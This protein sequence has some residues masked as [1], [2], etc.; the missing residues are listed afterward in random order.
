MTT[1]VTLGQTIFLTNPRTQDEAGAWVTRLGLPRGGWAQVGIEF[2]QP[3]AD[4]WSD[5]PHVKPPTDGAER[6]TEEGIHVLPISRR[7]GVSEG[8][9][10]IAARKSSE[11]AN[12]CRPETCPPTTFASTD[13][14]LQA[15]DQT[16]RQAAEQAVAAAATVRLGAVVNQAA[17]AIENFSQARMRSPRRAPRAVPPG[18]GDFGTR[19]FS[20]AGPT[21]IARSRREPAKTR[22]RVH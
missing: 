5:K 9:R 17:A 22:R 21:D 11:S 12:N 6:R 13:I 2:V 7:E 14:L 15:L 19:R 4:F 10:P 16:L 20:A 18:V 8:F 3:D 1:T